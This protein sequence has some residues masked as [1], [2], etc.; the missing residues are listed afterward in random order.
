[1]SIKDVVRKLTQDRDG[2]VKVIYLDPQPD[3]PNRRRAIR[4]TIETTDDW[5]I[6]LSRHD[7]TIDISWADIRRIEPSKP[8][9]PSSRRDN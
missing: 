9:E 6:R 5:G 3:N 4:G 7:G 1:M 8:H 2:E